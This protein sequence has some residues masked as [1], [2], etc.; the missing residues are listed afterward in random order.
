MDEEHQLHGSRNDFCFH[1][2]ATPDDVRFA[3]VRDDQAVRPDEG[4]EEDAAPVEALPQRHA[5]TRKPAFPAGSESGRY[6][7][8]TSDLRLVEA[9]L[10]QLS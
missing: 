3:R 8:R 7:A 9:A 4:R 10:S 6:W 1:A 5:E 2:W